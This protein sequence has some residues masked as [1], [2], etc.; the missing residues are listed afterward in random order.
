MSSTG[1]AIYH[2]EM[3]MDKYQAVIRELEETANKTPIKDVAEHQ[4]LQ[5]EILRYERKHRYLDEARGTI[6]LALTT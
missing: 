3:L 2:I 6:M 5:S 4:R 1:G